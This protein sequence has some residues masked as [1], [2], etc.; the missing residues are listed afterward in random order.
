MCARHYARWLR[1]NSRHGARQVIPAGTVGSVEAARRAG[2]TRRQIDWWDR[3]GILKPSAQV[4]DGSGS[5]RAYTLEDVGRLR[6]LRQ[7]IALGFDVGRAAR[8]YSPHERAKIVHLL[9]L[10][11]A[12]RRPAS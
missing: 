2:V 5:R 1:R 7:L 10:F 12:D 9:T 3:N 8:L 6:V 11:V 4:A